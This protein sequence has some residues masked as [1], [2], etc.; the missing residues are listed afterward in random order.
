MKRP[1]GAPLCTFS[2]GVTRSPQPAS[3][4]PENFAFQLVY[5]LAVGSFGVSGKLP[6]CE[7]APPGTAVPMRLLNTGSEL[8]GPRYE[9]E[10]FIYR[11]RVAFVGLPST[12]VVPS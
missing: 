6:K 2:T 4:V 9:N 10:E 11:A 3:T 5:S 8:V 7:N 1:Y 12:V